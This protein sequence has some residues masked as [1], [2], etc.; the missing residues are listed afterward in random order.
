MLNVSTPVCTYM[1]ARARARVYVCVRACVFIFV[2]HTRRMRE[3]GH[4]WSAKQERRRWVA[5]GE[6]FRGG[7]GQAKTPLDPEF[8]NTRRRTVGL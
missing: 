4:G 7:H 1:Y 5:I 3:E 2:G 8:D 6:G